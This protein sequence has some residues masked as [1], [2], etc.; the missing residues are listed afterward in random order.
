MYYIE[1]FPLAPVTRL[2][3]P[4]MTEDLAESRV[5]L[6][7]SAWN[8]K[9]ID[10]ITRAYSPDALWRERA[11]CFRGRK[12]IRAFLQRKWQRELDY[13]IQMNLWA[14]TQNR[15]AVNFVYEWH[16]DSGNGFRSHGNELWQ[17]CDLG[18][19]CQRIAC[20]NDEPIQLS[21]RIVK[22]IGNA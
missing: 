9:D 7:E 14:F 3:V 16:D 18:R 4:P 13:R 10:H 1:E 15:I 20:I 6:V 22:E 12:N 21:D 17:F 11:E 5:R 2:S 8:S 19:I